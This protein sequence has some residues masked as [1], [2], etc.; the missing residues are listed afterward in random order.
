MFVRFV[1]AER[2]SVSHERKG[3]FQAVWELRDAG[4]LAA[5]EEVWAKRVMEWFGRNMY[6][7][8]RLAWSTRPN[9]PERAISWFRASA[10]AHI[11]QV[12]SLVSL[13]EHK[14][15]AVEM[16]TTER[17]GYVVYEDEHQ[18]VAMPFDNDTL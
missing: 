18:V 1:I 2:D 6:N 11:A 4:Q 5:Y 10:T 16:L 9:A 13:L 15:I 12:R 8:S 3:V 7:P 17:P 14:D